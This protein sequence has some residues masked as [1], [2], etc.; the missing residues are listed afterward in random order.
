AFKE[1]A[2]RRH[3]TAH[4]K[5]A[6][7]VRRDQSEI[8][9]RSVCA[10]EGPRCTG[11][12]RNVH[13]PG[14]SSPGPAPKSE[15][16]DHEAGKCETGSRLSLKEKFGF[17]CPEFNAAEAITTP[18]AF[19]ESQREVQ[20]ACWFGQRTAHTNTP[21][22]RLNSLLVKDL[23]CWWPPNAHQHINTLAVI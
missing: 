13:A 15:R 8:A 2:D 20:L 23:R 5:H 14:S 11:N 19:V 1:G 16:Y 7:R 22:H 21:T 18:F 17:V 9:Q 3:S 6:L 4:S 12:A 10:S